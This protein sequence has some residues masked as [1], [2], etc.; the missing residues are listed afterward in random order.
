MD[1]RKPAAPSTHNPEVPPWLD[2]VILA[3]LQRKPG[4]RPSAAQ[5]ETALSSNA[6]T[7]AP[8]RHGRAVRAQRFT[9]RAQWAALAFVVIAVLGYALRSRPPAPADAN[10]IGRASCRE[11][12]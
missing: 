6:I 12:V 11:R 1:T 7:H 5:V 10:Q 3:M 2:D 9:V 4:L 8:L